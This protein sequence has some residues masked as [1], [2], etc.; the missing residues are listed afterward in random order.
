MEVKDR[1]E[2][3]YTTV[4]RENNQQYNKNEGDTH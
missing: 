2:M 3:G 4:K 1:E